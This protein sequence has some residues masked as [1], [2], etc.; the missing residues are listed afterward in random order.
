MAEVVISIIY[1]QDFHK[2]IGGTSKFNFKHFRN[3]QF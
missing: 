2:D 1:F 3:Q